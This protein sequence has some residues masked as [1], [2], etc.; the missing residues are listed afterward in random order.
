M[1]ILI[2]IPLSPYSG[3]GN[4][5]IGM[6]RAL[7][8]AGADVYLDPTV[9][10]APLPAEVA[11]LLTKP[12]QAPFDLVIS[13]LDPMSLEATDAM[14][15]SADMVVGWTM[16]EYT[17]LRNAPRRSTQ[18][19]RWKGFDVMAGYDQVSS[20]CLREF[21]R[22]PVI[23]Q[24]GGFDPSEWP[25]QER[26]WEDPRFF[27]SQIGVLTERKDPFVSIQAFSELR[28]EHEDFAEHAR[29]MLKT[30]V[31]GLHSKMED[32]FPGL[33]IFYDAWPKETV[34]EFYRNTHVL[35]APS[36][37]EGKNMPALEFLST[38][39]TV[40]ATNWGGHREWLHPE[41]SYPLD[42]ELAPVS[43]DFPGTLNARA[44]VE[45]MKALMLH[46]FRNRDEVKRK[47]EIGAQI[48]PQMSSWD[49]VMV[50]FF[51][52]LAES[53]PKGAAAAM[54]FAVT[55]QEAQRHG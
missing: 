24:Q 11:M 6:T 47:G 54:K 50:R 39:G 32:I 1:K 40:I 10:Q 30:S 7:I 53:G 23:T 29:L 52:K 22:G 28:Q 43:A 16:W 36:R 35:L 5:G 49:S 45:H 51:E 21:Y 25:E 14:C 55:R 27:F 4:D 3:Y 12:V 31:P 48:I 46:T 17:N 38:G 26:D 19:K 37:G 34:L 15:D 2:K 33:R 13:H 41:Y 44:S 9:A 8:R 20:D 42:Y 18:R